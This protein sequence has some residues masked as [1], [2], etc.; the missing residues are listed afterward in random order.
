MSLLYFFVT[1]CC[2]NFDYMS[3]VIA[4]VSHLPISASGIYLRKL[5]I[6]QCCYKRFL[7]KVSI[8]I[9]ILIL[10]YN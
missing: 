10:I 3:I 2:L 9:F 1:I 8:C 5:I 7:L 6:L 4:F